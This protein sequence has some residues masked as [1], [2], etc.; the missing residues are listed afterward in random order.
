MYK[1]IHIMDSHL[2]A[3]HTGGVVITRRPVGA[4]PVFL[5]RDHRRHV[6]QVIEQLVVLPSPQNGEVPARPTCFHV[7]ATVPYT[8]PGRR[9]GAV[10]ANITSNRTYRCP[11]PSAG[12]RF[13]NAVP[14]SIMSISNG[15]AIGL[16]AA[17]NPPLH[18]P[19]STALA[20]DGQRCQ[21][22]FCLPGG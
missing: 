13:G 21:R 4:V 12:H 8:G 11:C 15:K 3:G 20:A 10:L 17:D 22:R 16:F 14:R 6:V 2:E 1:H 19:L 5:V 18:L 7:Y 9:R